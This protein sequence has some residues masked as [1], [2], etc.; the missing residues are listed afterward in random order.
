VQVP[1]YNQIGEVVK[2]IE[3]SDAVFGVPFNESVVHQ[4]TLKAGEK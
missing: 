1:L 4:A 3:I 2:N